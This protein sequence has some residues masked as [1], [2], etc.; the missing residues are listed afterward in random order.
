MSNVI[1]KKLLK[2][3]GASTDSLKQ[4]YLVNICFGIDI[5]TSKLRDY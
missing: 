2:N 4:T 1:C 5:V 3:I